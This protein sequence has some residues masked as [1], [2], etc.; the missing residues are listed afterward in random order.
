MLSSDSALLTLDENTHR[1]AN[2]RPLRL[3]LNQCA[4]LRTP[5]RLAA[6]WTAARAEVSQARAKALR[7]G[8]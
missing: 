3:P 6:A 7:G 5:R 8:C 2:L 4:P 1:V